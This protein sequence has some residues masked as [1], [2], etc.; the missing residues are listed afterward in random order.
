MDYI[1]FLSE[2]EYNICVILMYIYWCR[3]YPT[4]CIR[5]N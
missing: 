2:A 4:G 1:M 3:V 5:F